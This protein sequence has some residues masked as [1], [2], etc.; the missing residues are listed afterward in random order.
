MICLISGKKD[1]TGKLLYIRVCVKKPPQS[2]LQRDLIAQGILGNKQGHQMLQHPPDSRILM[3]TIIS[4]LSGCI[5]MS[6][7]RPRY[8]FPESPSVLASTPYLSGISANRT[9]LCRPPVALL[10]PKTGTPSWCYVPD[11]QPRAFLR[12]QRGERDIKQSSRGD[13]QRTRRPDARSFPLRK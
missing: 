6:S 8:R 13:A 11:S 9:A 3:Q 2:L 1:R 12:G 10:L 5:L 7:K 4:A